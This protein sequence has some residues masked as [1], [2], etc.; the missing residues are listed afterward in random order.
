M[1]AVIVA[2][3]LF[4]AALIAEGS[5]YL[6]YQPARTWQ[7]RETLPLR[8]ANLNEQQAQSLRQ[9]GLIV[10]QDQPLL[11]LQRLS[12][13]PSRYLSDPG[14]IVPP[15]WPLSAI[16]LLEAHQLP[17]SKGQGVNICLVDSG[18]HE[19]QKDQVREA[20]SFATSSMADLSDPSGHGTVMASMI[21]QVAPE[22]TLS[23]A[24]VVGN[25]GQG[26]VGNLA[27]AFRWCLERAQVINL[28][29]GFHQ[30][31]AV[32]KDL[33]E[34]AARRGI[35]VVTAAGNDPR[36][37]L[38]SAQSPFSIA[39]GSVNERGL[40]SDF[41]ARGPQLRFLAPGEQIPVQGPGGQWNW[42]SGTSLSAALTTGVEAIRRSRGTSKLKTRA[43]GPQAVPVID[44]FATATGL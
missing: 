19:S 43:V 6:V 40:M 29:L 30:E 37:V 31:S 42:K 7:G 24:K 38:P 13:G 16:R 44:A 4:F 36:S 10:E 9:Q 8:R 34:E 23:V 14:G 11:L 39:V 1:R 28:S 41:S 18:L 27:E 12:P 5:Q 15:V 21:K 25:E 3:S 32:M 35:T 26:S 2:L 33:I 22:A 20:R 17:M